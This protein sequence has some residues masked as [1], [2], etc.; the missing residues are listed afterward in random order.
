MRERCNNRRHPRWHRY[1][2]RGIG[3]CIRWDSFENFLKDMGECPPG[4]TLERVKND[5][6]YEPG[7][8]V[9]A[10]MKQQARNQSTNRLIEYDGRTQCLA[11]WAEEFGTTSDVLWKR[12]NRHGRLT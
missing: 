4:L 1:G 10:S 6:G 9:W 12:L 11:A 7:N 3:C 8:C 2:G 5:V